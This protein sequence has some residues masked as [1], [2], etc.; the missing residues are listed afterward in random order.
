MARIFF[1]DLVIECVCGTYNQ[2]TT[3]TTHHK[4]TNGRAIFD[5]NTKVAGAMVHT[6]TS[7]QSLIRF[8]NSI[9]VPAAD[10]KTLRLREQEAGKYNQQVADE[11]C[12]EALQEEAAITP[13]IVA[14]FDGAQ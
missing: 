12:K 1:L 5:I 10:V 4:N 8:M 14:S 2:V 13:D 7:Q 3:D 11:S 6:G 9:E